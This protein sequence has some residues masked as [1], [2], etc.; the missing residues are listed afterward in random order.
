MQVFKVA[1]E[2]HGIAVICTQLIT[3]IAIRDPAKRDF[4]RRFLAPGQ[5]SRHIN[6]SLVPSNA[7][8]TTGIV[9][10]RHA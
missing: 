2:K 8:T 6:F 7:C 5:S 4:W 1:I 10:D 9:L 3:K